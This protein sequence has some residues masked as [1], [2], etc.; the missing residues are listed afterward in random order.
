MNPKESYKP[1]IKAP[2]RIMISFLLFILLG[3]CLLNL[4]AASQSR[5]S[6]GFLNALFTAT[7]AVC[8]TGLV[9]VNTLAHWTVF[10][11]I[12]ILILIQFGALGIMTVLTLGMLLLRRRITLK[13]R[14]VIQ[15]SYNQEQIGGMVRLVRNVFVY[16]AVLESTGAILL[17]LYFY[18]CDRMPL[19]TSIY[20]GIF[21]AVSAFCN[22][23]FDII[24]SESLTPYRG[25]FFINIVIMALIVTGGLGF[26]V[27]EELQQFI[28]N[29]KC[30]SFRRRLIHLSLHTKIALIV[31]GFLLASGTLLFLLLEWKNPDTLA[32]LPARE[33]LLSAMF[34]S[35]TLRTAGFNTIS[36]ASLTEGSQLLSCF[37]MMAGGSPAGTAG[38]MKTV[39]LGIIVITMFSALRGRERIE[40]F[41]RTLPLD[42]LQK[43]LTVVCAMFIVVFVSTL[44]LLFTEQGSPFDH[45]FLDLLF[46]CSSAAG[47]AGISTGITSFLSPVGKFVIIICMFL[48]RLSPVTVVVALTLKQQST[49]N[50]SRYID[51]RVIIG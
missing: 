30:L 39:T 20:K 47:T 8:V 11:K 36:Q 25:S 43:A 48:G 21:H 12:V 34:Q 46:E 10:G 44:I 29:K 4:P 49:N 14:L 26:T 50:R 32:S 42:L 33:K 35:V 41:G 45:S 40:A 37:Y 2:L 38:G 3:A 9:V 22:A 6:I 24:G 15:T 1:K 27:L 51:E 19:S 23:G 17:T 31:T 5:E 16:T 7:S 28:Q 18:F 13:D